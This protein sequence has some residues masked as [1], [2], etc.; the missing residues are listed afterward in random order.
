MLQIT[1]DDTINKK[2]YIPFNKG[3]TL[4]QKAF[5]Q[6]SPIAVKFLRDKQISEHRKCHNF[7]IDFC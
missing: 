3:R 5:T 4:Y 6:I 1:N 2:K 7:V